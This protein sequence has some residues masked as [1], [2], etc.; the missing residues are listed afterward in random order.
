[1]HGWVVRAAAHQEKPPGEEGSQCIHPRLRLLRLIRTT[2]RPSP[3]GTTTPLKGETDSLQ[4]QRGLAD[5]Q[6][7]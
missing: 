2:H 4:Q 1:M 7:Q 3:L 5:D 6:P